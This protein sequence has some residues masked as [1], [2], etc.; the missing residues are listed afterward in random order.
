MKTR[1][2]LRPFRRVADKRRM[3]RALIFDGDRAARRFALIH[4]GFLLGGAI[5][6]REGRR[7]GGFA[8]VRAEAAVLEALHAIS[9]E[10]AGVDGGTP[11]LLTTGDVARELLASPQVVLLTPAGFDVAR[12]YLEAMPWRIGIAREA[13]DAVDFLTG[14][15][16]VPDDATAASLTGS[17]VAATTN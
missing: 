10:T 15:T 16:E 17:P 3:K 7:A 12:R 8:D 5:V 9:R 1:G 11:P 6:T 14:A 2:R 4:E 13:V